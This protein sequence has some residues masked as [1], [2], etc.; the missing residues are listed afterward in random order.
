[1]TTDTTTNL[2]T[3]LMKALENKA[4]VRCKKHNI[5]YR[6][7]IIFEI[8]TDAEIREIGCSQYVSIIYYDSL[9]EM[10]NVSIID[11]YFDVS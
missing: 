2:S 11:R 9:I 3:N 4:Y 10:Q 6:P 1:M 7:S 5:P 8:E